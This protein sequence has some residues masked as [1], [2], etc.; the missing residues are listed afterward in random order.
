MKILCKFNS[1]VWT[2][3]WTFVLDLSS[4]FIPV[5]SNWHTLPTDPFRRFFPTIFCLVLRTNIVIYNMK[6]KN[7]I[8][9]YERVPEFSLFYICCLEKGKKISEKTGT[10]ITQNYCKAMIPLFSFVS[11]EL[12]KTF[13]TSRVNYCFILKVVK[14]WFSSVCTKRNLLSNESLVFKIMEAIHGRYDL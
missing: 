11:E 13:L 6:R 7:F 9:S 2:L 4:D 12:K 8:K 1:N 10:F 14:K 3:N 5:W